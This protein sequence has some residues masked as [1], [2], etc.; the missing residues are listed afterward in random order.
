MDRCVTPHLLLFLFLVL[1]TVV[2]LLLNM[3]C[4]V[5]SCLFRAALC[6]P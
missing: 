1:Y 2:E 4:V 3:S 6:T 5:L